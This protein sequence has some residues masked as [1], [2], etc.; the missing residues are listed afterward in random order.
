MSRTGFWNDAYLVLT[1]FYGIS[2]LRNM[3]DDKKV[4]EGAAGVYY[5]L[6]NTVYGKTGGM[7]TWTAMHE[8]AH[9]LCAKIMPIGGEAE[10]AFCD[11]FATEMKKLWD[12]P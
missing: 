8:F 2:K 3:L 4:P 12:L 7:N 6:E 5:S 10:Q 11:S 9:H 1:S